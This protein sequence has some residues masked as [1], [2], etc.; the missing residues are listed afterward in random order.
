MILCGL[1]ITH[2]GG[3]AL[4]DDGRLVFSVEMEKLGNGKRYSSIRDLAVVPR[5]LG[6]FGYGLRE[7]DR[8]V[9]DGWD[10]RISSTISVSNGG[11]AQSLEVAGYLEGG[12]DSSMLTPFA[13]RE[14][15]I[16]NE[17]FPFES[18]PHVANHV[19]G[20]WCTSPFSKTRASSFVLV[21]DGGMFPRLYHVNGTDASISSLGPLFYLV[22]HAY[23]CSAEHFG[24]YKKV[25]TA[26]SEN[27]LG[28]AGKL[29]AY[30]A[31]GEP[32]EDLVRA[33]HD[34]YLDRFESGTETARRYRGEIGGYGT[35]SE[36]SVAYL[37]DYFDEF[38]RNPAVR[39]YSEEDVLTSFHTFL[40]RLLV[41]RLRRAV[42]ASNL[43]D[44]PNISVAGGCALNIK[45]NSAIRETGMFGEVWVPP[46]PND[47]GAAIGAACCA[48]V[49]ADPH[50]A[51]EWD[52][53][54]G[55]QLDT[56]WTDDAGWQRRPASPAAVA[57]ILAGGAPVVLLHGRAELGPRALGNRSILAPATE[58]GMKDRLNQIKNREYYRPVAPIC[59][60]DRAPEV[61]APGVPDP[62]MLFDHDVRPEWLNRIPAVVHLDGTSRLQTL[63]R[64]SPLPTAKVLI[65]Y[66]ALT[67]IP[68]LCNTSANHLGCG[69][70]P[71][72]VSAAKWGR[73]DHIWFDDTLL[74][75]MQ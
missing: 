73:V 58:A 71:D 72:V 74:T 34:L 53:Y 25:R 4:V 13:G 22:G 9:V 42:A 70:F 24:P 43:R 19:L 1:K 65:E 11:S 29:M 68:L 26:T 2:D 40:E 54:S 6:E 10:G 20:A 32:R 46:F 48:L 18:Y 41:E 52:V 66:E 30:I 28:I 64:D 12:A 39:R 17:V 59:L 5:L 49:Q 37:H 8:F 63:R 61:F 50:A 27:D 44:T 16:G 51:L 23:A 15:R 69:F 35:K 62:F 7:V 21:W 31:L 45:W 55:P 3:V 57:E 14:L 60:E 47:S 67:G 33:F 36:P 38:A 75:R 56:R